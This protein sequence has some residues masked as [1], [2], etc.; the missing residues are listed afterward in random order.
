MYMYMCGYLLLNLSIPR[1]TFSDPF[2][3]SHPVSFH[4][5]LFH[6]DTLLFPKSDHV[7]FLLD[8][9]RNTYLD[10]VILVGMVVVVI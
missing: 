5:Y 8:L 3:I 7:G 9:V 10:H 1:W 4:C 2:F 6:L